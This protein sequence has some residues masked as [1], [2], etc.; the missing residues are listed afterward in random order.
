M[1]TAR[2]HVAAALSW[3]EVVRAAWPALLVATL[4]LLPFLNKAYT[5]DDPLFLLEARQ[6]LKTPAHPLAFD[7][8]WQGNETCGSAGD[9]MPNAALMGYALVPAVLGN[10]AEW[11][12]HTEQLIFAW[13]AILAMA[14]MALRLGWSR[15]HALFAALLLVA[16]PPFL[17]MASTAMP[18]ILSLCLGLVGLERLLAWKQA[19][20][21]WQAAAAGLALGAAPFGRPHLLLFLPLGAILLLDDCQLPSLPKQLKDWPWRCAPIGI[22]GVVLAAIVLLTYHGSAVVQATGANIGLSVISRHLFSYFLYL[23]VPIPLAVPWVCVH[24]RRA[25][26]LFLAAPVLLVAGALLLR[27]PTETPIWAM[28]AFFVGAAALADLLLEA[29]QSREHQFRYLALWLLIP[30]PIIFYSHFP[31][32]YLLPVAPAVILILLRLSAGMSPRTALVCGVLLVA[33]GTAYSGLILVA[34]NRFANLTRAAAKELVE[35][36][37]AAGERVWVAGQWGFYWYALE[38]G[39]QVTRPDVPGPYPGD[40]LAVPTGHAGSAPTLNRIPNRTLE[41]TFDAS[42][43]CGRTMVSGAGLYNDGLGYLLWVWAS[44]P[45]DRFELWRIH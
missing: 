35:R 32:K 26:V 6:I 22:A 17:P 13:V 14:A 20:R 24:W 41:R 15:L 39:A 43:A 2:N 12:A 33:V 29:W 38:A 27:I 23:A 40:L 25:P 45:F 7:V 18:D 16:I 37:V 9:I 44:G 30:F 1:P 11:I 4:C 36:N 28:V 42:C 31:I 3:P 34:D 21:W 5:I 19:R 8:C 10:G